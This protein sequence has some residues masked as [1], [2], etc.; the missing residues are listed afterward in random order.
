MFFINMLKMIGVIFVLMVIGG[1]CG[2]LLE[3]ASGALFRK[4]EDMLFPGL[5]LTV[6]FTLILTFLTPL[7]KLVFSVLG[8]GNGA[9]FVIFG[10][11]VPLPVTGAVIG[12]F[13]WACWERPQ[14]WSSYACWIFLPVRCGGEDNHRG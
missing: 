9:A 5:I 6:V 13:F 8:K 10:G 1:T 7:G 4:R 14:R 11:P 2:F 12:F 3:T